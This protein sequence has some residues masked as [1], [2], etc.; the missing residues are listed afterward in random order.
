[1]ETQSQILKAFV[2]LNVL[3]ISV[4]HGVNIRI[5]ENNDFSGYTLNIFKNVFSTYSVLLPVQQVIF[6][7]LYIG[8]SWQGNSSARCY[9][10]PNLNQSQIRSIET[11]TCFISYYEPNCESR[12]SRK[13]LPGNIVLFRHQ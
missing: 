5:Y 10:I 7:C 13:H 12:Y 6:K 1:M 11:D 4:A 2:F 8:L 9:N 3:I